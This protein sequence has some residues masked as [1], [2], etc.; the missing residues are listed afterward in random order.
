VRIPDYLA[1]K[2]RERYAIA[3]V[4]GATVAMLADLYLKSAVAAILITILIPAGVLIYQ[5]V[6][7]VK[8]ARAVSS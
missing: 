6:Q 2:S 3:W 8:R 7:R 4:A 5:Y 1:L